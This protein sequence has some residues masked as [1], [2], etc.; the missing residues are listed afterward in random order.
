MQLCV[1]DYVLNI[2]CVGLCSGAVTQILQNYT[3]SKPLGYIST[4][5]LVRWRSG[6]NSA[7]EYQLAKYSANMG[8]YS[9]RREY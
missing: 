4:N 3:L 8:R 9:L 5:H 6:A 1:L 2:N 7:G